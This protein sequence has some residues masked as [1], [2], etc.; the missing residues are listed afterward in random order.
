MAKRSSERWRMSWRMEAAASGEGG[1][2]RASV[3]IIQNSVALRISIKRMA[4]R[5]YL[6]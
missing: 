4:G 5:G 2:R 3:G 6:R 1:G